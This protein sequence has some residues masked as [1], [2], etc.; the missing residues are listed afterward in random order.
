V[1][2]TNSLVNK[3]TSAF[4]FLLI[5]QGVD[6]KEVSDD[7]RYSCN[8]C[9]NTYMYAGMLAVH[10]AKKHAVGTSTNSNKPKIAFECDVCQKTF[11]RNSHLKDHMKT[12]QKKD[13]YCDN[14]EQ[15]FDSAAKL[16]KHITFNHKPVQCHICS[17]QIE[18]MVKLREH[19][20]NR[21]SK[22]KASTKI[23]CEI[24][25]ADFQWRSSYHEHKKGHE[26]LAARKEAEKKHLEQELKDN[27]YDEEQEV[28]DSDS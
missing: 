16:S 28:T 3:N 10:I 13:I 24:C 2:R 6:G 23:V 19:K 5:M 18:S 8:H 11:K 15:V 17:K 20:R 14:C 1:E 9:D 26:E 22:N 4:I 12:H 7:K 27:E 25:G 21:H